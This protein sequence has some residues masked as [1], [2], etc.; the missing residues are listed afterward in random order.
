MGY[1][2]QELFNGKSTLHWLLTVETAYNFWN[3]G[4]EREEE[5]KLGGGQKIWYLC[6]YVTTIKPNFHEHFWADS[7]KNRAMPKCL[8]N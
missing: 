6:I 2:Q 3:E 7:G 8:A 1:L 4:L 5:K